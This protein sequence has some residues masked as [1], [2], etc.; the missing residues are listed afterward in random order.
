MSWDT[1]C[2]RKKSRGAIKLGCGLMNS[3]MQRPLEILW[4]GPLDSCN[5][6][7]DYCPFAK[8]AATKK[9]WNRISD[10]LPDLSTG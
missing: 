7:C 8:R 4:R 1:G 5:Y 6:S 10:P 2:N 3:G 9:Y